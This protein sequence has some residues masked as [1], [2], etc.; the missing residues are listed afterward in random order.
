MKVP[1]RIA[2]NPTILLEGEEAHLFIRVS[3]LGGDFDVT[4]ITHTNVLINELVGEIRLKAKELLY[5]LLPSENAEDPRINQSMP[6][7]LY[8]VRAFNSGRGAVL[9]FKAL[10]SSDLS[11]VL[12]MEPICFNNGHKSFLL[13]D[14]RDTFPPQ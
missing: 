2:S 10:L 12:H 9:T 5:P 13:R 8:H 6:R 1:I 4:S 3:S 11:K 14:F 7:E